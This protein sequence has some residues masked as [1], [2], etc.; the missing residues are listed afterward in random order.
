MRMEGKWGRK[1]QPLSGGLEVQDPDLGP[2]LALPCSLGSVYLS[3]GLS[4][5]M[6]KLETLNLIG[7]RGN[8]KGTI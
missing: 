7:L 5:L 4:F 2:Q 1:K 8:K 6:Y 3:Q